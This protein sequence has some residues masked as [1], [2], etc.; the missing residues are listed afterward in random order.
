MFYCR[1]GDCPEVLP[2][3]Q[4]IW[5]VLSMTATQWRTSLEALILPMGG[6]HITSYHQ[7]IDY[8]V[9]IDVA[10][11]CDVTV[12]LSFMT[13]LKAFETEVLTLLNHREKAQAEPCTPTQCE[14]CRILYGDL[15]EQTCAIC[16]SK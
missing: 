14:D 2:F 9:I 11:K 3:N 8:G 7:G 12:D 16:P 6:V 1:G 4:T 10:E 15:L 13:K 5:M